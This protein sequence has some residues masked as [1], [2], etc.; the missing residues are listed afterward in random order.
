L[1]NGYEDK[2]KTEICVKTTSVIADGAAVVVLVT[3]TSVAPFYG[4]YTTS[5][6]DDRASSAEICTN[7]AVIAIVPTDGYTHQYLLSGFT[8]LT[9]S[10]LGVDDYLHK[11]PSHHPSPVTNKS[12]NFPT[13]A[14]F[15]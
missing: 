6:A 8:P 15:P 12:T 9:I 11:Y 13:P 14:N 1:H 5:A 10:T 2:D 3:N 4:D 7:D